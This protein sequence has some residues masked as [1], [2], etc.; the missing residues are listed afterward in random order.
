MQE[1]FKNVLAVLKFLGDEGF[2]VGRDKIYQDAKAGL[3]RVQKDKTVLG[4]DVELYSG[5]LKRTHDG[6]GEL[7]EDQK[8]KTR[9]EIQKL[10]LQN[11]KLQFELDKERGKYL[12]KKDFSMEMAARTVVLDTG[13]RHMFQVNVVEYI[14]LAGGDP[15]KANLLLERLGHDLDRTMNSFATT[16][17]FQVMIVSGMDGE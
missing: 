2:K 11:E 5:T 1:R 8:A 13:L 7:V 9:K 12:P 14:A 6:D 16:D 10:D 15:L 4:V 17:T 3:L